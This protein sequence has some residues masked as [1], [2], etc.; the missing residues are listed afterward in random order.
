MTTTCNSH[1]SNR[2]TI[3]IRDPHSLTNTL[4][5]V[6]SSILS[7]GFYV[8]QECLEKNSVLKSG[9]SQLR[10]EHAMEKPSSF[11]NS[12]SRGYAQLRATDLLNHIYSRS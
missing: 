10:Q 2:L 11:L 6:A 8:A 3:F 9:S 7:E 12:S 5:C 4:Q 1:L